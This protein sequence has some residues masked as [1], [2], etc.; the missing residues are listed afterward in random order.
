V[1]T[2]PTTFENPYFGMAMVFHAAMTD[3][4]NFHCNVIDR[5]YRILWHNM[6]AGES[7]KV[8]LFC[9][10]FYQKRTEPCELCPVRRVFETA[11]PCIIERQRLERL[12]NGL[13]RWGEIRA[14]PTPG[15]DG[16]VETVITIG[17]DIT[18]R[19]LNLARQRQR[20][21]S[22]E[23]KLEEVTRQQ[24]K[25]SSTDAKY[26][27]SLTNRERQV[28]N[29][30]ARGFSNPEISEV[31]S[32]SQHTVKSHVIHIFNKLSVNDRTEAA[33]LAAQNKLI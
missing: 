23:K 5:N 20:I 9:Y 26:S 7:R 30:M 25:T 3:G 19:K 2:I 31:L 16:R 10:D 27:F 17:F 12:P 21:K 13:L 32:L 29:L 6:V 22:L 15:G 8:G 11:Q 18:D 24:S 28:L 1:N 4:I 14:Y 33:F